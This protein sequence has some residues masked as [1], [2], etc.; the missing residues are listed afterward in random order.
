MD[1]PILSLT[2]IS[3]MST[4]RRYQ[5]DI[6]LDHLARL[7][8]DIHVDSSSIANTFISAYQRFLLDAL[9][10]GQVPT[11]R[12]RPPDPEPRPLFSS[13]TVGRSTI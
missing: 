1:T 2:L 4:D 8:V 10:T 9:Y 11:C 6:S 5:S 3:L 12:P 7:L 13:R